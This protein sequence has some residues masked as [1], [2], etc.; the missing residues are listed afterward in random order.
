MN[1]TNT[2]STTIREYTGGIPYYI[3]PCNWCGQM[4]PCTPERQPLNTN[5]KEYPTYLAIY[6]SDSCGLREYEYLISESPDS[7]SVFDP[8]PDDVRVRLVNH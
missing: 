3:T 4:V 8:L 1:H 5:F 7:E 2:Q 6:C